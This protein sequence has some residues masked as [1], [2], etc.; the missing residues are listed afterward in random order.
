MIIIM[1][2]RF[3]YGVQDWYADYKDEIKDQFL[4]FLA[5]FAITA[6]FALIGHV[7]LGVMISMLVAVVRELTQHPDKNIDEL[8]SG[9][10]LDLMFWGLGTAVALSLAGFGV[11]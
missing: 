10:R 2:K 1:M 9:S 7:L 8:G 5:G 6:V 3:W 11:L 4:H